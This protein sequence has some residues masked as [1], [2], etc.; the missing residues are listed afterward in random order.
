[1]GRIIMQSSYSNTEECNHEWG[2]VER[3]RIAGTLHRKC[4]WCKMV[5]LDLYDDEEDENETD[6]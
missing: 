3:S 5:T 2:P 6:S 4:L 1:M